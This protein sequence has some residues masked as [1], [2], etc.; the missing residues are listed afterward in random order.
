MIQHEQGFRLARV[1]KVQHPMFPW[2]VM[3]AAATSSEWPLFLE[4]MAHLPEL[5]CPQ[6]P[7]PTSPSSSHA[8][9]GVPNRIHADNA[10]SQKSR[11]ANSNSIHSPRTNIWKRSKRRC[12]GINP[13]R[14]ERNNNIRGSNGNNFHPR[15]LQTPLNDVLQ[16][17]A[18]IARYARFTN[19]VGSS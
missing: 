15:K 2:V 9:P 10:F 4:P 19:T 18:Q 6:T 1:F 8:L 14:G 17:N 11:L 16:G 3:G 12:L 5:V 7:L 13:P